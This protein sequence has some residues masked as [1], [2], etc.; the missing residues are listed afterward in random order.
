MQ[1]DRQQRLSLVT[2][3]VGGIQVFKATRA[4]PFGVTVSVAAQEASPALLAALQEYCPACS[5]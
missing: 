2:E 5:E 3:G 1:G 4:L